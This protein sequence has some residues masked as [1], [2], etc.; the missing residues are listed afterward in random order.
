M[1]DPT[2][3][4]VEAIKGMGITHDEDQIREA[5]WRCGNN[6]QEAVQLLLPESPSEPNP[7]ST[8]TVVS[9]SSQSSYNRED[10]YDADVDMRDTETH[11]GSGGES[12]HDSTTVSYSLDEDNLRDVEEEGPENLD[13]KGGG[14]PVGDDV[15]LQEYAPQSEPPPP[16]YEDIVGDNQDISPSTSPPPPP[17]QDIDDKQPTPT[18][19]DQMANVSSSIEFPLTHF[20]E[21]EGRVHTDQWSIPYKRDESL[22]VC[23]VAA[24]KMI[25]E[26][27]GIAEGDENC[28]KFLE[29][30]MGDA[31]SKLITHEAV[32][33]WD[34]TI[35]EGILDM[36]RILLELIAERLKQK[37]IPVYLLTLLGT[38]F[39][40]DCSYHNKM[41]NRRTDHS[42]WQRVLGEGNVFA[43][44]PHFQTH[45]DPKGW[46]VECMNIFAQHGGVQ[47]I[48]DI[49]LNT[50]N[51]TLQ[52]LTALFQPFS[53]C[54]D[55]I[56]PNYLKTEL[57]KSILKAMRFVHDLSDDDMKDKEVGC[58][59][60]L[61]K[62]IKTLLIR[63]SLWDLV[64]TVDNL[65]LSITIR[66]LN[67]PHFNA[68][69]NALKE[70]VRLTE[71]PYQSAAKGVKSPI[72]AEKITD[73]L[74]NNKVLSIAL[75]GNL[76]QSQYCN[77]L[78]S[79]VEFL[80]TKLSLDELSTI[81]EMQVDKNPVQV[82][83]VHG[84]LA[85]AASRFTASHL[86][87]L[88]QLIQQ[89]WESASDRYREKLLQLIG[90]IGKDD[91]QG[92][93]ASKILELL[94]GLAHLPQLSREMVDLAL[95]AHSSILVDSYHTKEAEKRT[96]IS[97]CVEDIRKGTWVVAA[98]RQLH[99]CAKGFFRSGYGHKDQHQIAELQRQFDLLRL[100]CNS[101]SK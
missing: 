19:S 96:Y 31:F 39:N 33:R 61:L 16:R 66:M 56:S 20:Y 5:L 67:I 98:F 42:R 27:P 94:W 71:E 77:K 45:K 43:V 32:Y 21:L 89:S 92:K 101:L 79:I 57:S 36:C 29:R 90:K 70:V 41:R 24:I 17:L 46:L 52:E 34:A 76:H 23:M 65:R 99:R 51:I 95:E 63:C 14:S 97:K 8:Y 35:M 91:R 87:H 93:T 55:Y 60:E 74:V 62:S 26:G 44:M 100:T 54:E 37:P 78:Q 11:P 38:V 4:A 59:S 53:V 7:L 22:A 64:T 15:E 25:R 75:G 73:W 69:M 10:S 68:K 1:S 13:Y 58:V 81:W 50:E 84:I 28:K 12:D 47:A 80:G 72:T 9:S 18:P 40:A 48:K 88:F 85:A 3:E 49:I 86:D 2:E 83:N 82:E 30:T 6:P